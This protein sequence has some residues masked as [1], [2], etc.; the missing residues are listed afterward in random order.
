MNEPGNHTAWIDR[1][2]DTW[3][4]VDEAFGDSGNW[5]VIFPGA[6]VFGGRAWDA[7]APN[8]GPFTQASPADSAS[9]VQRVRKAVA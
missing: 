3:V 1:R 5:W 7:I 8:H 6:G 9:A 2:G 4:R